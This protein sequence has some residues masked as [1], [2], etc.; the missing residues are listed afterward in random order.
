MDGRKRVPGQQPA[1][2]W[3]EL[4]RELEF[5]EGR[6]VPSHSNHTGWASGPGWGRSWTLAGSQGLG[7]KG[8]NRQNGSVEKNNACF[9]LE[10]LTELSAI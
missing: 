8:Q 2:L 9:N 1:G 4:G 10:N 6:F 7:D 3:P 5:Q